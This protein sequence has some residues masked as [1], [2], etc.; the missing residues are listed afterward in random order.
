MSSPGSVRGLERA[1]SSVA[2]LRRRSPALC[3]P[4]ALSARR[5][6]GIAGH[7]RSPMRRCLMALAVVVLIGC[8]LLPSTPQSLSPGHLIPTNKPRSTPASRTLILVA[9]NQLHNLYGQ[10]I[11]FLRTS[12][13]DRLVQSAIRPVQL[14]FYGQD[15]L[16]WVV[17]GPGRAFPIVHIGDAADLSCT[18]EFLKFSAIMHQAGHGWVMAPGNHDGFFFGNM[19]LDA[20]DP[21]WNDW[22]TACEHAGEPMTKDLFIRYYLAALI[23]QQDAGHRAFAC[24][25]GFD[26]KPLDPA[27]FDQIMQSI[28]ERGNWRFGQDD[29][30]CAPGA[31]GG[32]PLLQAVAWN[33]DRGEPW[34]SFVVQEVDLTLDRS[35]RPPS[36]PGIDVSVRA[37][38]L[39][40][41]QYHLQPSLL[42]KLN[43]GLI[44]ELLSDQ[45]D[46]VKAWWQSPTPQERLWVLIGHHPFGDLSKSAQVVVND[47]R[48]LVKALL[49]VS[50]HTH[51]GQFFVNA[52]DESG[53]DRWLELNVGSILDW[54]PEFR[55]LQIHRTAEGWM[56][57]APR[58]P[59]HE[60]LRDAESV[61]D[62]DRQWE[63]KPG[64]ADYYLRYEDF[65]GLDGLN[66]TRT[67]IRLKTALLAAH[68]RLLC[69]SPTDK[70]AAP[71]ASF[72]P[73]GCR[74][75][76][77]VLN[78]IDRMI[79]GEPSRGQRRDGSACH[80]RKE[81]DQGLAAAPLDSL[82][83]FLVELDRFE[84]ER[85]VEEQTQKERARF[86]LSQ[87]IWASKYDLVHARK[88]L[89]DDWYVI[90]PRSPT[91]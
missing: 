80:V 17:E 48:G 86:C 47:L 50:G 32:S 3:L 4:V 1:K 33:I 67:E 7:V 76:D 30:Q 85:P 89:T 39:D 74:S 64:D 12:D 5:L 14:D 13:A 57:E 31:G 83:E 61:P 41:A 87:A 21:F 18:G 52:S 2:A 28:P 81:I 63:A 68:R 43:A 84:R 69:F 36:D 34:R 56:M 51:A 45:V 38:I 8:G 27:R 9:D 62:N 20:A 26:E 91:K 19:H 46:T 82:I 35:V 25:L 88:P 6:A 40:T 75:D 90:F 71:D 37:V 78:K 70:R 44:G 79:L 22:R 10:P 16:R 15:F 66:A 54:Q 77:D 42:P 55:F 29:R 73:R 53:H 60:R 72:W 49:Y 59:M 65:R 24:H 11:R 58:I 23:L